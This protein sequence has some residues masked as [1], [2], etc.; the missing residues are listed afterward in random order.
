MRIQKLNTHSKTDALLSRQ[1]KTSLCV[2]FACGDTVRSNKMNFN[3]VVLVGKYVSV[4]ID[5]VKAGNETK[6]SYIGKVKQVYDDFIIID[7]DIFDSSKQIKQVII[8]RSH[9]VSIW[10]YN[11]E[12]LVNLKQ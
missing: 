2:G 7:Y 9:I 4:M 12:S 5:V 11:E 10:I 1:G 3:F 8:N 6:E